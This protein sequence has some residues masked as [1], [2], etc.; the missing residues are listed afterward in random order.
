VA[1]GAELG[2]LF[3]IVEDGRVGES[4]AI[5]GLVN[6]DI[7]RNQKDLSVNKDLEPF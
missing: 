6:I 7:R 3:C 1:P 5:D 2:Q 4:R